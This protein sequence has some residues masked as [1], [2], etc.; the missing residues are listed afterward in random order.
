MILG[1]VNDRRQAIV[2]L[3]VEGP[4]GSQAAVPFELD[5]GFTSALMLPESLVSVLNLTQIEEQEMRLAD[6]TLVRVSVYFAHVFWDG[7]IRRTRVIASGRQPLLGMSLALGH[8]ISI[9][10]VDGGQVALT[11]L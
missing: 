3:T 5:T 10:M 1:Q 11:L 4:N 6:G 7:T 8:H 9:D 2:T